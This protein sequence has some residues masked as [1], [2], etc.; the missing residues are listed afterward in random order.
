MDSSGL[1]SSSKHN[2]LYKALQS[3]GQNTADYADFNR[4][5]AEARKQG[6]SWTEGLEYTVKKLAA[7]RASHS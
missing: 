5:M 2:S 7:T 3:T 1:F 6:L 4:C